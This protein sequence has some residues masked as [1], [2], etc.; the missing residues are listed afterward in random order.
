MI[1]RTVAHKVKSLATHY[2]VVMITGPRQSGKT[3]LCR[4]V[5]PKKKYVLFEDPDTREFATTDP[6]G[7]LAQYP[8]GAIF[9][10]IQR[11]PDIV[12]YLQGQV[13][14]VKQNGQFI[15]TGS[16]NLLLSQTVSQSLAGRVAVITL[17]PFSLAELLPSVASMSTDDLMVH[18]FYPRIYDEK[19]DPN[20]AMRFYF[21]T[22]VE[23]DVRDLLH[24]KDVVRF[25]TFVKLCAGR[26]G[27]LLNLSALGNEAGVSHQTAR[28][29]L[30]I[31]EI[32][33][34]VFRL[35]PYHNNFNKRVVKTPKLYFYDTGLAS[36]LLGIE[37]VRQMERDPLR[38]NLFENMIIADIA[39]MQYNQV[40]DVSLS[41]FR[42]SKGNEVDLLVPGPHEL[43][44]I[45]IK[46]GQ[47]IVPDYF[48]G[49]HHFNAV[50]KRIHTAGTYVVYGGE[51]LQ[52]RDFASVIPF[53][54]WPKIFQEQVANKVE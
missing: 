23:R 9:D 25:Q 38:G 46:S 3:T 32:S 48:K 19:L 13:D 45:E 12:S 50:A 8:D 29:W 11:V 33:F 43:T 5:F 41:F 2:P 53:K 31:L 44:A 10:E 14:R 37:N 7:F 17:L 49:L 30:S 39:K 20:N 18:G 47:T 42:D 34:I 54:Q 21:Q 24:V 26:I 1:P 27:Q 36:Y 6:R 51:E 16:H 4:S 28:D 15:L 35:Q 22:Y 52:C 40:R